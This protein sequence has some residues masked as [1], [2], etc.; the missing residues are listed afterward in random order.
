M[1]FRPGVFVCLLLTAYGWHAA[2]GFAGQDA[3]S[4]A[5]EEYNSGHYN[6]AVESLKAAAAQSPNDAPLH[7]LLG[8][9]YYQLHDFPRAVANF[10][11]CVELAKDNSQ[12]HDWLGRASGR[13][14]EESKFL[15]AMSWARKSHREFELAVDL[16]PANF[17][18]QRDLIRF[19]IYAPGIVGGGDD[20]AQKQIEELEKIDALQGKLARGEFLSSRKRFAESDALFAMILGSKSDQ[21][22]V[23]LEVAEYY[24]DRQ[25]APK[26]GEAIAAA[27]S[28]GA[29]DPRL[30]YY[31]GV[32]LVMSGI[33]PAKAESS[34]NT[35][36]N[37]VPDDA[38]FPPHSS[39][40]EWLGKLYE[41]QGRLSE[42]AEQYGASLALDAHSKEVAEA[43]KRVQ[44]K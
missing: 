13:R 19:E 28:I 15:S 27:E 40:H 17:E 37:T 18:A 3:L 39:A 41:A 38:D 5:Q 23:Y 30:N 14:A 44:K 33:T 4:G 11:R 2:V 7:F 24:R 34:L 6:R 36:L 12:Y 9:S 32:F 21:I 20:R 29:K 43:L 22:G 31:R 10:E 25:N 8:L 26:M 1:N 16:N 42:A 35:Y